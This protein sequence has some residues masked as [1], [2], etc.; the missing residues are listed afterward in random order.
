MICFVLA[1]RK[2]P[3]DRTWLWDTA[4][5]LFPRAFS[6]RHQITWLLC[7]FL[8]MFMTWSFMVILYVN[9]KPAQKKMS[10]VI[11]RLFEQVIDCCHYPC[12]NNVYSD[13]PITDI[14]NQLKLFT[15]VQNMHLT[16]S[17]LGH[18]HIRCHLKANLHITKVYTIFD[19]TW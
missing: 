12:W 15:A 8:W 16:H 4:L 13:L 6:L 19:Q 10:P 17:R 14:C 9:T 18:L 3:L 7:Q 1:M 2:Q 11:L 5:K